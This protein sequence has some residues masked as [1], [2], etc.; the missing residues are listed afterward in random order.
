[1]FRLTV[2]TVLFLSLACFAQGS[3]AKEAHDTELACIK[4]CAKMPSI[5]RCERGCRS[6]ASSRS[7]HIE[8]KKH[9][10]KPMHGKNVHQKEFKVERAPVK[11]ATRLVKGRRVI[12]VRK[13]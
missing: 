8:A 1:M 4:G 11:P 13:H 12:L 9:H 7:S 6:P 10:G 3:T 5:L 2:A